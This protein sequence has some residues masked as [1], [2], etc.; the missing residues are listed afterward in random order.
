MKLFLKTNDIAELTAFS[1]N[2]DIDKLAPMINIAQNTEV[3][4]ILGAD[5]YNKIY[6]DLDTLSGDYLTVLNEYVVYILAF[7]TVSVYLSLSSVEITNNETPK[8]VSNNALGDSYK[9]IAISYEQRL[10]DFLDTAQ[11]PEFT[12][13]NK[14][15][16]NLIQWH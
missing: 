1:G 8:Q 6:T 5:L 3:R 13:R 11:L 2:I 9:Q 15:T 4:R 7:H 16:T 14:E 12:T 10:F